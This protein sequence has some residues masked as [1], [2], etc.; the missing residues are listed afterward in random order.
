MHLQ[1]GEKPA[2]GE[3]AAPPAGQVEA[4]DTA[5]S[6]VREAGRDGNEEQVD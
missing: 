3:R 5:A 4:P 1:V 6:G 2:V